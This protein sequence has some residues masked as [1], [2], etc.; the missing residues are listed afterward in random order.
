MSDALIARRDPFQIA[1]YFSLL[2]ILSS[3]GAGLAGLPIAFYLK[4]QIHLSPSAMATFGLL[5]AVPGYMGFLFGFLRDRWRPFGKGDR[6]YLLLTGPPTAALYVWLAVSPI[7][8]ANL[9]LGVL[10][11]GFLG[12]VLGTAVQ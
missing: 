10:L 2:T 4:D 6:G 9:L 5:T 3:L 8:Y 12:Q 11:T 7:T 1:V